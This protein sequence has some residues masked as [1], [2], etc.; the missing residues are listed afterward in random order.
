MVVVRAPDLGR[1]RNAGSANTF[2]RGIKRYRVGN[3]TVWS[4]NYNG[5]R[6]PGTQTPSHGPTV[7]GPCRPKPQTRTDSRTYSTSRDACSGGRVALRVF[8]CA[9][10]LLGLT[11]PRGQPASRL[12]G[13]RA[14]A[15]PARELAPPGASW[16]ESSLSPA[17]GRSIGCLPGARGASQRSRQRAWAPT[18]RAG[19]LEPR[20]WVGAVAGPL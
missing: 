1:S 15:L 12:A 7:T 3:S 13:S 4:R 10:V 19:G 6:W 14:P 11:L 20:T 17:A 8:S 2:E 16:L 5:K 9:L 18:S